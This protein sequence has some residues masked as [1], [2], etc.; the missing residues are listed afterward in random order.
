MLIFIPMAGTGDRYVKAGYTAPKPLI[1]VD[2]VPMIKRVI[3]S[4]S[5]LRGDERFL[6]TVNRVHAETTE[7]VAYLRACVPDAKIVVI[8]NHKDGPVATTLACAEHIRDDEEVVLNYCD[9]GVDWS[10]S[11]FRDWLSKGQWQSAMTAY[12]G[13]HPHALGPQ[14]YAYMR[15]AEDDETVVEIREKHHFTPDKFSEYASSGLYYFRTGAL[16]KESSR[17]LVASGNRVVGEYYSS[18]VVQHVIAHG[19]RTGV[20]PLKHFYQWGTPSDLRDWESWSRAM[21]ELDGFVAALRGTSDSGVHIIPMAG[22]GQRFVDAGY[23]HP[24]PLIDVAGHPMIAQALACL[25]VPSARVLVAQSD[26]AQAASFQAVVGALPG[27]TRIVHLAEVTQG[28]ACT[29]VLGAKD[30]DPALPVLFAPCDAGYLYDADALESLKADPACDMIVFSARNHLPALWRPQMYGWV[31]ADA[32]GA[33]GAVA[34]KKLV[35]GV[36]PDE[37]QVV[38]GTFWFRSLALFLRETADMETA[39]DRVNGEFYIDTLAKRLLEKG[40]GVRAFEVQKYIPWGTPAE[41]DTFVYW[42]DVFRA[43]AELPAHL[44]TETS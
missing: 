8:D 7:L 43:G 21:R 19:G 18:M 33:I 29:A 10:Y 30:L 14:L 16:L 25:P 20:F 22:R 36:S 35:D 41:L 31:H 5:P 2:G 13:F 6:F 9:F 24:K 44:T 27:A 34:V 12:R 42:N 17:A 4:F 1:E 23:T 26:H 37:Q 28:Q 11:A 15:L 40:L 38:T 39:N 3:D 32:S